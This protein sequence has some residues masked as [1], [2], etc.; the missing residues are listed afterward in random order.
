MRVGRFCEIPVCRWRPLREQSQHLHNFNFRQQTSQPEQ[1]QTYTAT[2]A[3]L[4][5]PP[6]DDE[7]GSSSG[8]VYSPAAAAREEE[9]SSQ[10]HS[11]PDED[12]RRQ[13][14]RRRQLPGL[15]SCGTDAAA[16]HD[17]PARQPGRGVGPRHDRLAPHGS[18][19][20]PIRKLYPWH[21]RIFESYSVANRALFRPPQP[22]LY[23]FH[24]S[25]L[26]EVTDR[27]PPW[28]VEDDELVAMR[29]LN[30]TEEVNVPLG[31]RASFAMPIAQ[32]RAALA[33][34]AAAAA[35]NASSPSRTGHH[36]TSVPPFSPSSSA[37]GADGHADAHATNEAE[38]FLTPADQAPATTTV[39]PAAAPE[40]EGDGLGSPPPPLERAASSG[41]PPRPGTS[42]APSRRSNS[43]GTPAPGAGIAAGR[44]RKSSTGS[45]GSAGHA[46]PPPLQASRPVAAGGPDVSNTG[47]VVKIQLQALADA[48]TFFA[49]PN[50]PPVAAT[51]IRRQ[52]HANRPVLM[53]VPWEDPSDAMVARAKAGPGPGPSSPPASSVAPPRPGTTHVQVDHAE[54]AGGKGRGRGPFRTDDGDRAAF[55]PCMVAGV[56][57]AQTVTLYCHGNGGDLGMISH[58]VQA[59]AV[60]ANTI[61]VA[62]DYPG[63]GLHTTGPYAS[64][65]GG[66]A[67]SAEGCVAACLR[68]LRYILSTS[69]ATLTESAYEA[70]SAWDPTEALSETLASARGRGPHHGPPQSPEDPIAGSMRLD[71]PTL[72]ASASHMGDMRSTPPNLRSPANPRSPATRSPPRRFPASPH[73]R[74]QRGAGSS[75]TGEEGI[76]EAHFDVDGVEH[77]ATVDGSVDYSPKDTSENAEGPATSTHGA[78]Q[79]ASGH[80]TQSAGTYSGTGI[81]GRHPHASRRHGRHSV[82]GSA[83][84]LHH[85]PVT[86]DR[87]ILCG[88]SIGTG[89]VMQLFKMIREGAV[90]DLDHRRTVGGVMLHSPFTSIGAIVHGSEEH[91]GE[92]ADKARTRHAAAWAAI[93]TAEQQNGGWSSAGPAAAASPSAGGVPRGAPIRRPRQLRVPE[94]I[95]VGQAEAMLVGMLAE[96]R[97]DRANRKEH[98]DQWRAALKQYE[99]ECKRAAKAK[100]ERPEAPAVLSGPGESELTDMCDTIVGRFGRPLMRDRLRSIDVIADAYDPSTPPLPPFL[101]VHGDADRLIPVT[102]ALILAIAIMRCPNTVYSNPTGKVHVAIKPRGGHNDV[103]M[104]EAK[105]VF[106]EDYVN[107]PLARVHVTA[108]GTPEP[109]PGSFVKCL[110]ERA[111]PHHVAFELH[112]RAVQGAIRAAN[113]GGI[114]LL[115]FA[116][117]SLLYGVVVIPVLV[118]APA[119]TAGYCSGHSVANHLVDSSI[120][121][122]CRLAV[123]AFAAGVA[124]IL[125]PHYGIH[126][127]PVPNEDRHWVAAYAGAAVLHGLMMF[128]AVVMG[129][130]DGYWSI[131][132]SV[133]ADGWGEACS[134]LVAL[135]PG[136]LSV[137]VGAIAVFSAVRA[138]IIHH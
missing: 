96:A 44:G 9:R 120:A 39:A 36:H 127:Q 122:C 88:Q 56:E 76:R 92:V 135:I 137:L 46:L 1:W 124:C 77:V 25:G 94:G 95:D 100:Q 53:C 48:L 41:I 119:D 8:R 28:R 85:R 80:H 99:D 101:I 42:G 20:D 21:R 49:A 123:T 33:A 103:L 37:A 111:V 82:A 104:L 128:A 83:A 24:G 43:S 12:P 115:V 90:S 26:R 19:W 74:P 107:R 18:W 97:E 58:S 70:T 65:A 114:A 61:C 32:I 86:L 125:Q 136:S 31:G 89:V 14:P 52:L 45:C 3:E 69:T 67:P 35:A 108:D 91:D 5:M 109:I 10:Q 50:P 38:R 87:V 131:S 60:A 133:D 110:D 30:S 16:P 4:K 34:T 17:R 72:S 40:L 47:D 130:L 29:L 106:V 22:P 62:V 13:Q 118:H 121:C 66:N 126:R 129:V 55:I 84:T 7:A 132:A 64:T 71:S 73:N 63:F 81:G 54:T 112:T 78:G 116:V 75:G 57:G 134:W 51:F 93:E 68:V 2:T 27:V 102:H 79:P 15:W 113:I 23:H 6:A 11:D 98:V 117:I 105:S 59:F 138:I